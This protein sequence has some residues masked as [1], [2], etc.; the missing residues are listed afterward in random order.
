[1]EKKKRGLLDIG[2]M[3]VPGTEFEENTECLVDSLSI[4][5]R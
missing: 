5:V 2:S 3:P 1:M 4:R